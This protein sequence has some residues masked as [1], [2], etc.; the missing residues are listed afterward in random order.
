MSGLVLR[1]VNSFGG[2]K[3]KELAFNSFNDAMVHLANLTG[4][5]I[6]VAAKGKVENPRTKPR[7]SMEEKNWDSSDM[8]GD[9][10]NHK[11]PLFNNK[12]GELCAKRAKTALRYLNQEKSKA[13]Y[14]D[15]K[16]RAK[17]LARI[18]RAILKADSSANVDYQPRDKTYQAL[19]EAVKKK[20]KG[21]KVAS[22]EEDEVRIAMRMA[23]ESTEE[24]APSTEAKEDI[25]SADVKE[26]L[27][28]LFTK[29]SSP[30]FNKSLRTLLGNVKAAKISA[31]EFI[32]ALADA[33]A[34]ED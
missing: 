29:A 2:R 26:D 13:S 24:V 17:V 18:I 5:K 11:Y 8:W 34:G 27:K 15:V 10:K 12:T 28:R 9:P 31:E 19:P 23:A 22:I 1:K 4:S 33:I 3:M 6:L 32:D 21:Y 20:M 16:S 7:N 30:A 14:P 25:S